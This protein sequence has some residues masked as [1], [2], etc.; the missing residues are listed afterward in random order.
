MES[1]VFGST[2]KLLTDNGGKFASMCESLGIVIKTT[3]AESSWAN[4]FGERHNLIF[5]D[6]LDKVLE[7]TQ[8]DLELAVAWCVNAKN[9]LSNIHGFSSYQLAICVN[10]K[11]PSMVSIRAPAFTVTPSSKVIS[12]NLGAIHNAEKALIASENSETLRRALAH[13]IRTSEDI[14]YTT[15][16]HVYFTRADSRE[17]NGPATV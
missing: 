1:W 9:S 15:G 5:A 3:T 11:L 17:W 4:G 8:C 2:A 14:K 13:N 6:M 16:D 7:E 12:Y 10:P